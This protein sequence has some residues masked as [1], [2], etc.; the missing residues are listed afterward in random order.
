M[1]SSSTVAVLCKQ[2]RLRHLLFAALLPTFLF[3][4][5]HD[6][7][8]VFT[9]SDEKWAYYFPVRWLLVPHVL[10]GLIALLIGPFQFSSRFRQGHLGIHRIMGRVYLASVA[11]SAIVALFLSALHQTGMQDKEWVFTLD[12]AW[13]ITG[14]MAFA[15]VRNG[16][17]EA[18]RQWI[19]RNYGFTTIFVTVRVLNALPIP[20]AYGF[21]PAWILLLATL[22][23]TEI[24]LA[25]HNV[26]TNRRSRRLRPDEL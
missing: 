23:L 15:A 17:I 5:W 14:G 26:F 20:D 22:L 10:G 13:L 2:V 24:G 9:H 8:F 21:A 12:I 1:E 11:V 7:R 16:N 25:W 19:A 3:V 4:L 6:E 18:H